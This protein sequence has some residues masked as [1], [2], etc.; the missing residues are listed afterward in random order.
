[1]NP[2]NELTN[3]ELMA[4]LGGLGEPPPDEPD[5]SIVPK[6]PTWGPYDAPGVD[7]VTGLQLA[8]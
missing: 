3:E 5:T 2:L 1:M 6:P 7:P 4:T 8:M